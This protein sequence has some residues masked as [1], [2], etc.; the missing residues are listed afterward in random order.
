MVTV[1]DKLHMDHEAVRA[2]AADVAELAVSVQA[3]QRYTTSGTL[4]AEHLG[5]S[6]KAAAAFSA[7]D[8]AIRRL[9][10]SVGT[11]HQFLAEASRRLTQTANETEAMDVNNAWGVQAAGRQG[12]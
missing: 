6:E 12:A 10:S 5:G 9:E 7:Y 8:G 4:R 3:M 1:D 11:A 2:I